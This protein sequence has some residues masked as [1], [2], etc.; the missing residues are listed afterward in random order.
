MGCKPKSPRHEP[1]HE[2][3][4]LIH[5]TDAPVWTLDGQTF[6]CKVQKVYDGDS[7][8]C[9]IKYGQQFSKFD[10]RVD[11]LDTPEVASG[12]V[13]DFGK[14]VRDILQGVILGKIVRVEAGEGDKYGRILGNFTFVDQSGVQ[15][16]LKEF[17][18]GNGMAKLYDGGTKE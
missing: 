16:E 13:R 1:H 3:D 6:L 4:Q 5:M 18:V 2:Y 10:F 8:K 12:D 9:I 17:L 15:T 7:I 11:G 14:E